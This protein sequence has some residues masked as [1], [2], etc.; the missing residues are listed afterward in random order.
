MLGAAEAM[1]QLGMKDEAK[2]VLGQL[3]QKYPKAPAATK[4]KARLTE[5]SPPAK[6]PPPKKKPA[7]P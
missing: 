1:V 7:K 6:P 5:L 4:A 3:V 2:A